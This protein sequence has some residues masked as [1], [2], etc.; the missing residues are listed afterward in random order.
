[1]NSLPTIVNTLP[2]PVKTLCHKSTIDTFS[3]S[4]PLDFNAAAISYC[5]ETFNKEK[6]HQ[7]AAIRQNFETL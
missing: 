5:K 3:S 6:S 7:H 1:M 2:V 4:Q